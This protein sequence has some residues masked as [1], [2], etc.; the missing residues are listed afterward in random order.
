MK[1]NFKNNIT[2]SEIAYSVNM[3]LSMFSVEFKKIIGISL[4]R[5]LINLK[6]NESLNLLKNNYVTDVAF[7]LGYENISHFIAL[8]KK[9]FGLTPKQYKIKYMKNITLN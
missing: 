6:L 1:E 5:Y 3:A 4:N 2:I 9:K 7:D 8:F